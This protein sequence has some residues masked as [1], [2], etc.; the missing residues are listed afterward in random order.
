MNQR[1]P[2]WPKLDETFGVVK[3]LRYGLVD[4][5]EDDELRM[6]F[7]RDFG[8][9]PAGEELVFTVA[10]TENSRS[11]LPV[12]PD[13]A[14]VVATDAHGRPALLRHRVGEGCAR[15]VHVPVGAH[16]RP[17]PA[18]RIRSRRGGCTRRSRRSRV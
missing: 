10:G 1:G 11:Y 7:Q 4:P 12:E 14:E 13:G 15:P 2:W 6:T 9:I 16:G 3:K 8:G 18:G 5:V 17:H